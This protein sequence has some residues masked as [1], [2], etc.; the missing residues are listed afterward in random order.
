MVAAGIDM[1]EGALE[2]GM[3]KSPIADYFSLSL[4]IALVD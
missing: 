4:S 1:D 3:G 2:I